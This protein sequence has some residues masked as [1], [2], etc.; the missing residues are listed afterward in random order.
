[1][2]RLRIEQTTGE[3]GHH[4]DSAIVENFNKMLEHCCTGLA[5]TGLETSAMSIQTHSELAMLATNLIM[6]RSLTPF[7]KEHGISCMHAQTSE[8][9]DKSVL[10]NAACLSLA[11]GSVAK[12][13]RGCKLA[14][15]AY[16][17]TLVSYDKQVKD[18]VRLLPFNRNA[19]GTMTFYPTKATK[20]YKVFDRI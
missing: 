3:P 7:Q 10:T 15:R 14:E 16:M 18:A 1:M 20:N 19:D 11:Y 5:L 2:K 12:E 6:L 8:V 17:A 4:T 9:P 13:K